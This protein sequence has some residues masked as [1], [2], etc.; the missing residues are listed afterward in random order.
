MSH[1]KLLV[2]YPDLGLNRHKLFNS[3]LTVYIYE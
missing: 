1:K 2:I 3:E